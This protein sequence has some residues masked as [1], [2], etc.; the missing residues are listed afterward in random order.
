MRKNQWMRTQRQL[1]EIFV[2]AG[3]LVH[4][5][6]EREPMP[7]PFRDVVLWALY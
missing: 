3:L 6:T 7:D 2:E 5:R 4:S 1:E